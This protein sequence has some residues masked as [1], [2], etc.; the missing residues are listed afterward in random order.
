MKFFKLEDMTKGWFV[1]DFVPS[2]FN[3]KNVEVAVKNYKAGD[4]EP[5]HH[6]KIATELTLIINGKAVINGTIMT[7]GDIVLIEPSESSIFEVQ[8]DTCTVVVKL[9][10]S[11]NDKYLD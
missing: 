7:A 1:G 5:S 2:A 4:K 10:S 3:S 6:H 9:P 11:R 8:E